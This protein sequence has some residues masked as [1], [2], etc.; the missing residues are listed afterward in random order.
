VP[1]GD[2]QSVRGACGVRATGSDRSG[3]GDAIPKED[4][5]VRRRPL[6]GAERAWTCAPAH[7][8]PRFLGRRE[9]CAGARWRDAR[10]LRY[11]SAGRSRAAPALQLGGA[12]CRPRHAALVSSATTQKATHRLEWRRRVGLRRPSRG[13]VCRRHYSVRGGLRRTL[14]RWNLPRVTIIPATRVHQ[15]EHERQER[16][17]EGSRS[18]PTGPK[19]SSCRLR[20]RHAPPNFATL[21]RPLFTLRA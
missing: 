16:S 7:I 12:A 14:A 20:N 5:D 17:G 10:C 6:A 9:Y 19:H 3:T 15:S 21:V 13:D 4:P 2:F 11:L 18:P 8:S 1:L